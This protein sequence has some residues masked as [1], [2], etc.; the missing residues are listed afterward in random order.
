MF[1][2]ILSKHPGSVA[3]ESTVWNEA[4]VRGAKSQSLDNRGYCGDRASV[5]LPGVLRM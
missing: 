1:V 2:Q 4:V 3:M 5:T